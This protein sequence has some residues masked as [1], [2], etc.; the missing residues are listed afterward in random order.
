MPRPPG[1]VVLAFACIVAG[2]SKSEP[3]APADS[4]GGSNT[5]LSVDVTMP[6]TSFQ[7]NRIDLAQGGTIRFIF[8]ALAHD[9]RFSGAGS[10]ADIP[11]T[12]NATITRTFAAKGSYSFLCSLH[13]NMT[14]TVVVH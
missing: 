5:A 3:T 2:C 8:S 6:G 7:P 12:T 14:G 10:P 11:V 4:A 9:V 1:L 13:A